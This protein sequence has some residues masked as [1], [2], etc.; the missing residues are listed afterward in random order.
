MVEKL[1][2]PTVE[3][4]ISA[5]FEFNRRKEAEALSKST[6]TKPKLSITFAREFGCEAYPAMERLQAQME[7]KT[8]EAWLVLD[9]ALLQEVARNHELS[10]DVLRRLGEKPQF[11]DDIISTFAPS[12][13]GDKDCFQLLCKHVVALASAGNVILVGRGSAFITQ[14]MKNCR[15]VFLYGS[16]EFKVRSICRRLGI[17]PK[18]AKKLIQQKQGERDQFL[19]TFLGHTP[20]DLSVYNLVFNNDRNTPDQIAHTVAEYVMPC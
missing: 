3:K 20:R 17:E 10:E 7:N 14:S 12:W 16:E 2:V 1:I 8:G 6:A 15:H 13:K 18:E 4:R 11:L 5:L 9:K 19:R